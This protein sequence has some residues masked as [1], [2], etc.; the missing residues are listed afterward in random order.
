MNLPVLEFPTYPDRPFFFANFVQTV[1]GKVT[2]VATPKEYWPIGSRDDYRLLTRLRAQ[3]DVL[4]HGSTTARWMRTLDRLA[5]AE[6]QEERRALGKTRDILY[7]AMSDHPDGELQALLAD[8]P[9]GTE[10]W[11][12]PGDVRALSGRLFAE[13]YRHVLV[14][15]GPRLFTSFLQAGLM[16]EI[17]LTIAPKLFAGGGSST[18]TLA[19][20]ELFAPEQVP[21]LELLSCEA[22]ENEV[23]LRYATKHSQ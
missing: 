4:V 12:V 19:E 22:H 2:V 3:A 5:G 18:L 21:S 23:Y 15:G 14:E 11:L 10:G 1:D 17:F 9:A 7:V 16:D 20:G 6:F 8:P 13:G